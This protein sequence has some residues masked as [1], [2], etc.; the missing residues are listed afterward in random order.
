MAEQEPDLIYSLLNNPLVW[1]LLILIVIFLIVRQFL[2][3]KKR[4][5]EQPFYGV[6]VRKEMT[7]EQIRNRT[8]VWGVKSGLHLRRGIDRIGKIIK[9]ETFYRIL[10]DKEIREI[11]KKSPHKEKLSQEELELYH[12]IA[13]RKYGFIA[14]LKALFNR[15]ENLAVSPHTISYSDKY[16]S[17]DPKAFLI[18]DSGVWVLSSDKEMKFIDDLNVKKDIE[19]IKGFN[20]DFLRR[21]SVQSPTQ[22]M[23]TE[24]MTHESD[25]EEKKRKSRLSSY[26]GGKSA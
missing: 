9:I 2:K 22:A 15:Y 23:I 20:A 18:D 16:I 25:L 19:N 5:E 21:L 14:W 24:K 4:P 13:F 26:T 12:I 11:A 17:L 1:L 10:T 7:Q 8:K 6:K 3:N